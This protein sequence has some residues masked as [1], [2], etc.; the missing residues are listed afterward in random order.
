MPEELSLLD[1][2]LRLI[3]F[4]ILLIGSYLTYISLRAEVGITDP[5]VFTP[6]GLII[7]LLGV[8]MLIARV[9]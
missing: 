5:R 4:L 9:R 2:S 6:L 7:A 1:L 3:G 8:F